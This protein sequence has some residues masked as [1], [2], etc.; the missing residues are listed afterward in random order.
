MRC[1]K[2]RVYQLDLKKKSFSVLKNYIKK[3][4][5]ATIDVLKYKNDAYLLTINLVNLG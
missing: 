4:L 5:F 1:F 3:K 2:K